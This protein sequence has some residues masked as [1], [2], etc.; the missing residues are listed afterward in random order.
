MCK[1]FKLPLEKF[2]PLKYIQGQSFIVSH[3][4]ESKQI[5]WLSVSLLADN[6]SVVFRH[7]MFD[8]SAS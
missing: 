4:I 3:P 2:S 7:S 8:K 1:Y 5:Q 6:G